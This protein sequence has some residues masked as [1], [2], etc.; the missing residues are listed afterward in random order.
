MGARRKPS[1]SAATNFTGWSPAFLN[2]I[3]YHL[4]RY[5]SATVWIPIAG[6]FIGANLRNGPNAPGRIADGLGGNPRAVASTS[7]VGRGI[8]LA[9]S[10]SGLVTSLVTKSY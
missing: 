8:W 4:Y 10:P 9:P 6:G 3:L 5:E 2:F 1:N 7:P